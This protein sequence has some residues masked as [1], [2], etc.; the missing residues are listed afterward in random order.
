MTRRLTRDAPPLARIDGIAVRDCAPRAESGFAILESVRG[1]ATTAIG[2]DS[3]ICNDCL[4]ELFDPGDRRYR[5]A[6]INCT[7][8]GPRYTITRSLPYDRAHDQHGRVPAVSR[9]R[10]RVSR[11]GASPFSRGAQRMPALRPAAGAGRRRRYSDRRRGSDHRD[12]GT[13]ERGEI[14]AIKGLGGFHLA[15][16]AR[17]GRPWPGC[18]HARR[19]R[20]SHLRSWRPM[21]ASLSPFAAVTPAEHS[22]L[23]SAERPIVLL[24]KHGRADESLPGVAPAL[25]WLGAMLPYTPLQYLLFHEAA[26]RPAGT[27]WLEVPHELVLVMTSAN[28]GGE[29]LVTD[30]GEAVRRLSG[31]A[32]A[33]LMHDRA[34]VT[35]CDDSVLRRAP[36]ARREASS[37]SAAP[38]ATHRARSSCHDRGRRSSRSAAISRI[39]FALR[40]A[41]RHSSRSTSAISTT[42]HLRGARRGGRALDVDARDNA[43]SGG[44]R[45]ASGLLQHAPRGAA[46]AT[47]GSPSSAFST[48]CAHCRSR[49]RA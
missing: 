29:P 1:H 14:V 2:P 28:P 12:G 5:Y 15:C 47:L 10:G 44:A 48:S 17:N 39:R 31:I 6:F 26:G 37:S 40:V 8:C 36:N 4:A 16:D 41:T 46:R 25:A 23:D 38:A 19:A 9:M 22:L 49:R 45:P 13:P 7:H 20:R 43:R 30:N 27:A 11:A 34:I 24:R 42:P 21:S 18:G 3:A 33:L 32:D 35:R